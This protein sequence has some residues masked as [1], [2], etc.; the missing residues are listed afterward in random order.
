MLNSDIA[1]LRISKPIKFGKLV[2]SICL[3]SN[4]YDDPKTNTLLVAGWGQLTFENPDLPAMLQE[5]R[6]NI[7]SDEECS[8]RYRGKEYTIYRS[9][10]C[11]WNYKKDACQVSQLKFDLS[12]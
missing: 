3:P 9:Q 8:R 2:K 1:L 4:T 11:T 5:V 10:I 6:L 12:Y 7:I